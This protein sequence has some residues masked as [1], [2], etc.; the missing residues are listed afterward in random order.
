LSD[1]N[2]NTFAFSRALYFKCFNSFLQIV[3]V[4]FYIYISN[5]I[6]L[7]DLS[8]VNPLSHPPFPDFMRVFLLT[9]YSYIISLAMSFCSEG[10]ASSLQRTKALSSH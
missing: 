10:W 4:I 5:V 1:Q 7:H 3:L 2:L 8:S 6:P 9:P